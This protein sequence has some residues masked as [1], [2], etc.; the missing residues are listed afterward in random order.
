M[1]RLA[2]LDAGH[3]ARKL[4]KRRWR[5][6]AARARVLHKRRSRAHLHDFRVALRRLRA[7]LAFCDEQVGLVSPKPTRRAVKALATV[8]GTLRDSEVLREQ[9]ESLFATERARNSALEQD[10]NV[11]LD[12]VHRRAEKNFIRMFRT[13]RPLLK[14]KIRLR[15]ERAAP[16]A[17]LRQILALHVMQ[18]VE[19][20]REIAQSPLVEPERLHAL[21]IDAKKVRYT[22]EAIDDEA[23]QDLLQDLRR[24]QDRL[25]AIHDLDHALEVLRRWAPQLVR[26]GDAP[27]ALDFP[28]L[29]ERAEE[30][31]A[32]RLADWQREFPSNG[33]ELFAHVQARVQ[34][35]AAADALELA[36]I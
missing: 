5:V 16:D 18:L 36:L 35:L 27:G 11:L 20:I 14:S 12:V 17:H 30:A 7:I 4:A 29:M 9:L 6:L 21:R 8:S 2:E 26:G 15:A 13:H 28:R 3:A 24:A 32:A 19:E 1:P 34:A 31:R 25:G 23:D 10:C 22:L 33:A